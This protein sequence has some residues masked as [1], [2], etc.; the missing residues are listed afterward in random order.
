MS[1]V[2]LERI[3]ALAEA[4]CK[5]IDI[6]S[7]DYVF[8]E[9]W[10]NADEFVGP[11]IRL[12]QEK[13]ATPLLYEQNLRMEALIVA[14]EN[15]DSSDLRYQ[16]AIPYLEKANK[17][18]KIRADED[19]TADS[20]ISA[21]GLSQR[22]TLYHKPFMETALDQDWVLLLWP[23]LPT[24][25]AAGMGLDEFREFNIDSILVDY[26]K[27]AANAEPLKEL[28]DRTDRVHLKGQGTDLRFS[29]KDINAVPCVGFCNLPD[30]EV[31]A[32]PVRDSVNGTVRYNTPVY[33]Q[34]VKFEN[35][36]LTFEN[37]KVVKAEAQSPESTKRLNEILDMD[38]GA[39]FTGEFAIGINPFITKP[40]GNILFDEK[41]NGSFH[42]A[43]GNSYGDAD[44]GNRSG[45]HWDMI[46]IQ[47]LEYGGGEIWFD[48]VLI[49]KDGR[50]LL[51][52]LQP[53]DEA[54]YSL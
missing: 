24:A 48:D 33:Q 51:P 7:D 13:G 39:R 28:F 11:L 44:N 49:R 26:K 18:I 37:G 2:A 43:L 30:G 38:E 1:S 52:E 23:K 5:A 31:Y 29:I 34:G 17:R 20:A 8:I 42:I 12:I 46:Q 14:G 54:D 22:A 9:C 4:V 27:L 35:I 16:A 32:S 47:T 36:T 25:Q 19:P 6:K 53:L 15:P 41:I 10:D 45:L 40:T 3:E 21:K 50:F